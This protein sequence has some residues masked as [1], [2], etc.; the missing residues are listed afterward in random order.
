MVPCD[1]APPVTLVGLSERA[2][3]AGVGGGAPPHGTSVSFTV[4]VMPSAVAVTVAVRVV[5]TSARTATV[6]PVKSLKPACTVDGTAR[7]GSSVDTDT[8]PASKLALDRWTV[9]VSLSTLPPRHTPATVP[10][11]AVRAVNGSPA[12]T[13]MVADLLWPRKVAVIVMTRAVATGWVCTRKLTPVPLAVTVAGT[14]ATAGSL[15]VSVTG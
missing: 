1:V 6:N 9:S 15:L 4:L 8:G 12:A 10:S 2:V 3:G 13:V 11:A 5:V 14:D 7:S